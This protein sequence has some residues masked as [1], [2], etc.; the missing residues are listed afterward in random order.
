MKKLKV[1]VVAFSLLIAGGVM[2]QGKFAYLDAETLLYLMPETAKA[3]TLVQQYRTDTIQP[4]YASLLTNYKFQDSVS[5]DTSVPKAVRDQAAKQLP[6]YIYQLQNWDQIV[7]QAVEAKQNEL[8]APVYK[9]LNDAINIYWMLDVLVVLAVRERKME[10]AARL[11]GTQMW[12]GF[13][14]LLSPIERAERAADLSEVKASLDEERFAAL[15]G[16]GSAMTFM[17][18][19]ALVQEE[20]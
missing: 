4:E 5:R 10:H 8:L 20:L 18:I 6:S 15:Q 16:E 7:Q 19:L 11:F 3:D 17:Q 9:K 13:A 14:N 12:R 2:A 1:L